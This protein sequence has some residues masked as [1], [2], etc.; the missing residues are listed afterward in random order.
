MTTPRGFRQAG[1]TGF[2]A[3][4]LLIVV[5]MIGGIA[6]MAAPMTGNALGYFRLSGDARGLSNALSVT[7]MRAAA[8]FSKARVYVDLPGKSFHI[9]TWRKTGT[10][11]WVP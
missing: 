1:S 4:E 10:P 9:E 8:T 3:V 5:A 11:G 2:S 7:K 6:A